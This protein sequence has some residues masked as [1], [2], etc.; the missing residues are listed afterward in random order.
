MFN[1]SIKKLCHKNEARFAESATDV[2]ASREPSHYLEN[3]I[4][5][6]H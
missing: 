1:L 6:P 4:L 3:V 2:E 5:T